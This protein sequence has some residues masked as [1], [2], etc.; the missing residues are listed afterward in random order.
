MNYEIILTPAGHLRIHESDGATAPDAWLRRVAASFSVSQAAGLFALAATRPEM[1]PGPVFSFW[2]DFSSLYLTR[3]CRTPEVGGDDLVPIGPPSDSELFSML[4]SAPPMQGGEYLSGEVLCGLWAD[5]DAWT[6]REIEVS[7]TGID[8]W[9]KKHAPVWHP[10]GRVCFH[11]AENKL[12]TE[13]P[14][15]FLVTYAPALSSGSPVSTYFFTRSSDILR[16]V[17]CVFS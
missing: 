2:R 11:L 13:F 1:P 10:L 3:L 15:A 9:L 17:T 4:L 16:M 5:V 8:R 6:R 12:D 7:A 14:F